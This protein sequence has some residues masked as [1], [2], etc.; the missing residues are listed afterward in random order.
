[1]G[2]G[3]PGFIFIK[4]AIHLPESALIPWGSPLT[5]IQEIYGKLFLLA[6]SMPPTSVLQPSLSRQLPPCPPGFAASPPLFGDCFSPP[7]SG[8]QHSPLCPH[9]PP[10]CLWAGASLP[11]A[12]PSWS[13]RYRGTLRFSRSVAF[14]P[15]QA[16]QRYQPPLRRRLI[17]PF[18][19]RAPLEHFTSIKMCILYIL[20]RWYNIQWE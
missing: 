12:G 1:M 8:W 11:T 6:S 18:Y 19:L 9:L 7:G 15:L 13:P 20:L 16:L 10:H 14:F 3:R 5:A 4:I 17:S 2:R